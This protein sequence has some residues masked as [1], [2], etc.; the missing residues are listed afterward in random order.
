MSINMQSYLGNKTVQ[1]QLLQKTLSKM[2]IHLSLEL[3]FVKKFLYIMQSGNIFTR[4]Y[5]GIPFYLLNQQI[6]SDQ[7]IQQTSQEVTSFHL[8]D[9]EKAL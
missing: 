5:I 9:F 8:F 1:A 7:G 2:N 6:T 4:K 3:I